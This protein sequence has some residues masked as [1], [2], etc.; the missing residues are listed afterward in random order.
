MIG[1]GSLL[2]LLALWFLVAYWRRRTLP[3]TRLFW[4][5]GLLCGPAAVLA[6]ECGWIVTEIGRQPWVVYGYLK[7]ADAVTTNNVTPTLTAIV[8]LY[9]GLAIGAIMLLRTMSRRW[10]AADGPDIRGPVADSS[11]QPVWRR[12]R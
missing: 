9:A 6:M 10:R 11:L 8:I 7:T 1:L 3:N 2:L 4:R 12:R 5:L